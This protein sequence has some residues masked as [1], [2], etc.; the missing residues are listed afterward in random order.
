MRNVPLKIGFFADGIWGL[1]ALK[2]L[3]KDK[4]FTVCFFTPRF[5]KQ[6]KALLNLAK[7]YEIAIII[8]ENINSSHFIQEISHFHCDLLVSMSFNQIFKKDLLRTYP[9]INCHAGKLPYYRGKNPINW[10]LI[11]GEKEFGITV[12]FVDSGID[13]GDIILQKSFKIKKKDD[14][15]TLL[16][17]AH[18]ECANLLFQSCKLFVKGKIQT[19]TQ[20][21]IDKIGSYNHPRKQGDEIID[22]S[23]GTKELFNF[24]R[25]LNAPDLGALCF[26]DQKPL[27]LYESKEM[28][29][30]F[31]ERL[32]NGF[33]LA[34][35][36]KSFLLK[37]KDGVLKIT[38][39]RFKGT[40]KAHS[41]LHSSKFTSK[42][43]NFKVLQGGGGFK[44]TFFRIFSLEFNLFCYNFEIFDQGLR[45]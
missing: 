20:E 16:K 37:C 2:K 35:S 7:K 5:N 10:A 18:A 38:K 42:S 13:T 32:P 39:Y 28:S 23:K 21:S 6:D 34:V 45:K 17:I 43:Q 11:N 3:H 15:S 19:I 44:N 22:F 1:N 27:Y 26:L 31:D 40:L 30:P 8:S 25:A 12:H 14:Y 36:K 24:I 41:Q 33:I 4:D 29:M 9:I